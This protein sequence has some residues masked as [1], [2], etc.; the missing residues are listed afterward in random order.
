[1]P[2]ANKHQSH[3]H[4]VK[5]YAVKVRE[6]MTEKVV[7]VGPGTTYGE[8][9]EVLL[10]NDISGVPVVAKDGTLLGMVTEAD[11][12]AKEAYTGGRRR[13]LDLLRDHLAGHDPAWVDKAAA[14]TAADLM[15][16]EVDHIAP[17]ADLAEAA[18][19]MLEGRHKR[20]PVCQD[21]KLVGIVS[22]HDL[23]KP[24]HR[25]DADIAAD[26]G[27]LLADPLRAPERHEASYAVHEGVVTLRGTTQFRSDA[28]VLVAFVAGIPGVV[29]VE[30]ELR[31]REKDPKV[32]ADMSHDLLDRDW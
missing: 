21:G 22:R 10:E 18:R 5:R 29:A 27:A 17:D 7:S 16:T 24:F 32:G 20:L 25:S 19:L 11:L 6:V 8:I 4:D 13:H 9:V 23:L 2:Q 14:R 3:R 31:P 28:S 15:S 30:D 12:I 1:M 26:V